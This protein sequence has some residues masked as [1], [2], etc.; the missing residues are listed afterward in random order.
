MGK[1]ALLTHECRRSKIP[2]TLEP[3]GMRLNHTFSRA[4]L[5]VLTLLFIAGS[6]RA[7]TP[8]VFARLIADRDAICR[9]E[10]FLLTLSVY[11]TGVTLGRQVTL[12]QMPPPGVATIGPFDELANESTLIEGRVYDVRRY[13]S[14][15]RAH[16]PGILHLAPRVEGTRVETLSN[17]WF[18][19]TRQAPV[20]IS[21][22]RL[23]LDILDLPSEGRPADFSGAV[24]SFTLSVTA[25]PLAVAVG[26]L[27]TVTMTVS[28]EGLPERF[29]PPAVMPGPGV[30]LYEVKSLPAADAGQRVFEQTV[31]AAEPF[32]TA[33]PAVS[34]TFF[35]SRERRYQ[36]V[37]GGPFPLTFHAER[38]PARAIYIP[39][40]STAGPPA[41]A[42]SAPL[43]APGRLSRAWC[44][45][46]GR[47]HAFLRPGVNGTV[48][49][50]PD[51]EGQVL[52]TLKP[53][54]RVRIDAETDAWTR[55]TCR[56]G[57]GWV[58]TASLARE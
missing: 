52:F 39:H 8:P 56:D 6:A 43:A 57:I 11:A 12:S 32:A 10:Q 46:T 5:A 44:A 40:A 16:T 37:I 18:M 38:A 51:N 27:V 50:A 14:R 33:I 34:F 47:H 48:H 31:V 58:S 17:G 13:R 29:I 54:T 19:Q 23:T 25:A 45:L 24:G 1:P 2:P 42:V 21:V 55:I 28:G 7:E 53:G 26:D 41:T 36:T 30:K 3:C 9:D 20:L 4:A 22:E 15:V 49:F 35:N